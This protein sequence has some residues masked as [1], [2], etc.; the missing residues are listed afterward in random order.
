VNVTVYWQPTYIGLS[1]SG[2]LLPPQNNINITLRYQQPDYWVIPETAESR[3]ALSGNAQTGTVASQPSG[4]P[5]LASASSPT[6]GSSQYYLPSQ[7]PAMQQAAA[8]GPSAG[9]QPG[10]SID[11]FAIAAAAFAVAALAVVV[12]AARHRSHRPPSPVG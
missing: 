3:G 9:T 7:I 4:V 2:L 8:L 10:A 12:V 5:S 11:A 6:Q 1:G